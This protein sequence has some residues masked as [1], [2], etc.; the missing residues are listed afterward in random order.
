MPYFF[1]HQNPADALS[2]RLPLNALREIGG[3][4]FFRT[5]YHLFTFALWACLISVCAAT[6]F[7]IWSVGV[8]LAQWM[9]R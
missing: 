2:K 5:K 1:A 8:F 3:R 6:W 4:S 7:S 9:A